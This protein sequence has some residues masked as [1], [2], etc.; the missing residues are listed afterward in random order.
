[1]TR[2]KDSTVLVVD[3]DDEVSDI[4]GTWLEDD[5]E[6][7]VASGGEEALDT[8]AE[9]DVEIVLLDRL[10]SGMSGEE[11]LEE[12]RA[13]G[14]DC[15]VAMVTAIEPDFDIV[16]MGFDDYMTKPSSPKELRGTVKALLERRNQ[17]EKRREYASLCTK[18]ATLETQKDDDELESSD[19]YDELLSRIDSLED[20]IDDEIDSEDFV[21]T[22]RDID[23]E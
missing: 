11:T 2:N 22:L 21:A 3:D 12:I 9:E 15:A 14:Y 23:E 5:Y 1:M 16:E 20:E 7:H 17:S 19:E 4:F 6:V 18:K 13:E 10:M 8:L